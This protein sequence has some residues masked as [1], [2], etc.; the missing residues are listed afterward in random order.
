VSTAPSLEATLLGISAAVAELTDDG[1]LLDQ[2]VDLTGEKGT[3]GPEVSGG[4]R[5]PGSKP[6]WDPQAADAYTT[7]HAAARDMEAELGSYVL[8]FY[9]RRVAGSDGNTRMAL[10]RVVMFAE[11][12]AVPETEVRRV[13]LLLGRLVRQVQSLPAIDLAPAPPAT[14]RPPCPHCGQGSLQAAVDGSTEI[15]C[16]NP[17]C[18]D[19]TTG[20]RPRWP[21]HRWPFLLSRLVQG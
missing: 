10:R 21:K 7:I 9:R 19:P 16:A 11:H 8:G 12:E 5:P 14:L 1:G 20:A 6:P 18:V 13:A 4:R 15:H 3:A 17:A 2:L